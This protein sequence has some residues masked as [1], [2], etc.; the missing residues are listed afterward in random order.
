[1]EGLWRQTGDGAV[2]RATAVLQHLVRDW[3]GVEG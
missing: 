3:C 2:E 1:M